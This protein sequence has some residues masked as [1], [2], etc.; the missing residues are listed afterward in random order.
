MIRVVYP[1]SGSWFFTIPD[2]GSRGQKGNG[3]RIQIRNTGNT[4]RDLTD[5][6]EE[7]DVV[8]AHVVLGEVHDGA[9]QRHLA[10]MVGG[11]LKYARI[12]ADT[13]L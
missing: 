7:I 2:P 8:G 1:G 13:I 5:G 11:N 10:V 4:D 6:E 9:L 3:S 12:D